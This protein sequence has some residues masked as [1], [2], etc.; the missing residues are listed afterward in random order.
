MNEMQKKKSLPWKGCLHLD[1][2]TSAMV[3]N[4]AVIVTVAEGLGDTYNKNF[5]SFLPSFC[6]YCWLS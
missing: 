4:L 2:G 5:Y 3:L 1:V 6:C